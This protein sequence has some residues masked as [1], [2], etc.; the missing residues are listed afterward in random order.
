MPFL[1]LADVSQTTRHPPSPPRALQFGIIPTC[2][3]LF[4]P[5]FHSRMQGVE[6]LFQEPL[7][8]CAGLGASVQVSFQGKNCGGF[9][10]FTT[11][12]SPISVIIW[13]RTFSLAV[14]CRESILKQGRD[15]HT[16]RSCAHCF[17]CE[18]AS[19]MPLP[20]SGAIPEAR[21]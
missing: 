18:R 13:G 8:Q 1:A 20:V 3:V 2:Q 6:R 15:R 11:G 9:G 16:C 21:W 12:H 5:P 7:S 4:F 14:C 19:Y 17:F 10:A